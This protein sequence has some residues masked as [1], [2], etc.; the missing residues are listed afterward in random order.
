MTI[1]TVERPTPNVLV[2]TAQPDGASRE[3]GPRRRLLYDTYALLT[4][5]LSAFAVL[6]T[7][8]WLCSH[9][10]A[11]FTRNVVVSYGELT[12]QDMARRPK[13][14]GDSFLLDMWRMWVLSFVNFVEAIQLL[15]P[16]R[17]IWPVL[18][19]MPYALRVK[20]ASWRVLEE[21]VMAVR[22]VGVQLSVTYQSGKRSVRFID[23]ARIRRLVL[24]EGITMHRV[25]V[26]MAFLVDGQRRMALAF[27]HLR[28]D[29]AQLISAYMQL[30]DYIGHETVH[31]E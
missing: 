19:L 20:W 6:Q 2:I 26:Y 21:S 28:L 4:I 25:I 22:D 17:V 27:D 14:E 1:L 12:E 11:G 5:L 7:I 24:N 9:V 8:G 18:G 10:A 31:A 16:D 3:R 13:N 23:I 29:Q 30:R 15:T